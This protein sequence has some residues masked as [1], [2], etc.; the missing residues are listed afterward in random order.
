MDSYQ[1]GVFLGV[2]VPSIRAKHA[3]NRD[4][5]ICCF[6]ILMLWKQRSGRPESVKT[7]KEL[8]QALTDLRQTDLIQ[9]VRNGE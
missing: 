1:L 7:Y 2:D 4:V 5:V 9:F 6:E 3:E 8:I